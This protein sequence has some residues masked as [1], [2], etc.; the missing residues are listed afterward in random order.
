MNTIYSSHEIT[1]ANEIADTLKDPEALP[2][3]LKYARKYKEEFLRSR[4][5]RVMRIEASRIR[6]SRGALFTY[7]VN[8]ASNDSRY[9]P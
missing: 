4:L 8:Q 2:L 6:T 3:Y 9:Q 5:E 1:L 7:L